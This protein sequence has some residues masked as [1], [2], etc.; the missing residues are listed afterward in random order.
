MDST[1]IK[2]NDSVWH[3][4][5]MK[6]GVVLQVLIQMHGG[7]AIVVPRNGYLDINYI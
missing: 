6:K 2:A 7:G 4:S 5:Y 1:L 3:K